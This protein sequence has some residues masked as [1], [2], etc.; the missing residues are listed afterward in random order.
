MKIE[1]QFSK[2]AAI[3]ITLA[4]AA[5]LV[6]A[7]QKKKMD[8]GVYDVWNNISSNKIS[9]DGQWAMFIIG[10][11]EKDKMLQIR[12]TDSEKRYDWPRG[13]SA[14]FSDDSQFAAF[15]IKAHKDSVK[16]AKRDKK[17]KDQMPKDSLGMVDLKDGSIKKVARVKSFKMPENAGGWIAWLQHKEEKKDGAKD[18]DKK[19]KSAEKSKESTKDKKKK[20]KEDGTTL[21]LRNLKSG[22]EHRF[23]FAATYAFSD[24]GKW[25]IYTAT[26][27]DST[28]DGIF[29]VETASGKKTE[30]L[31]GAGDYKKIAL[32]EGSSQVAFLSNRDDYAADKPAYSL[33]HW[34][35][36]S[37]AATKLAEMGSKGIPSGWWVSSHG[38]TEFSKNGKRLY[39]GTAPK[40][41]PDPEEIPEDEQVKLDVWNWKDPLLQPMQL[42]RVKQE[43]ERSYR[44]VIHLKDKRLVQLAGVEMP[45]LRLADKGNADFAVGTSNV[46]YQKEIS[47]DFPRYNDIYLVDVEKGISS[48]IVKGLQASAR[49]SPSGKYIYWWDPAKLNWFAQSTKS[50]SKAI[51]ISKDID[52]R[53]DNILH[54]WPYKPSS[55]GTAGWTKNDAR[56]L[57][58]DKFDMWALDPTGKKGPE[59]VTHGLGREKNLQLRYLRTDPEELLIDSGKTIL[60]AAFHDKTKAGGFYSLKISA[61]SGPKKLLMQDRAFSRPR[62]AK[63]DDRLLFTRS[64]FQEFPDYWVSGPGVSDMKKLTNANPQQKDYLWGTAEL[65]D[66]TSSDG[67]PLQGMLFK[68]ENFDPEKK[69]PMMVYFYE[70]MSNLLHR[71]WTPGPSRSSINFS[72]YVNRGYVVFIPDIPYEVGFPGESAVDAVIPGVLH[73]SSLGFVDKDRIGVQGHSWGGYQIAHMVTRTNIFRAAEAGAPVSNMTSAYGGIRW[74]SGMSRMFQYEKTQSRIGGTLWNAQQRYIE[75][76]PVFWADKI[77][78]PVLMMH[79]DKD[80]AVP[81]YQGIEFFVALRR[82]GKPVWMLNYNGEAHGL[83]KYINKK[84]FAIRMQQYFDHYLM[85]APAPAWL[86]HGVPA[87]K[88]GKTLGL[89]TSGSGAAQK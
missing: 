53:I 9:A 83:R 42:K 41:E 10:P 59:S 6:S 19:K 29:A 58:Y 79:N 63:Y 14:H 68:P 13:A 46:P 40:P 43:K 51:N 35:T 33:Y 18:K 77:E 72:F 26:S 70:K 22:E 28:A 82:L 23:P 4:V 11:S 47:W 36:G 81:W 17:K 31:A 38:A 3:L 1:R 52:V 45:S 24:D 71:H 5:C 80:G 88:K 74:A 76:S 32:D 39:F 85:D 16:Q 48:K 2:F 12:S 73:V 87:V 86:E 49:I 78:T 7:Q 64:S 56:L 61:N 27:K 75:N 89:E 69:Y 65:V 20:K 34:K 50:G 54:D 37:A 62:K 57:I 44:A 21:V 66:W 30:L 84:D 67:A 60:L 15:L 55:Y 25:L 8:H